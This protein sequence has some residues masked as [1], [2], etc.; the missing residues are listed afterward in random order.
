MFFRELVHLLQAVT[1]Q[2]RRSS[3]VPVLSVSAQARPSFPAL[4]PCA[5]SPPPSIS[6]ARGLSAFLPLFK[7]PVLCF[8]DLSLLFLFFISLT[9]DLIPSLL[10]VSGLICSSLSSVLRWNLNSR[11][12]FPKIRIGC[13]RFPSKPSFGC[14]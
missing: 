6:L 1:V 11:P 13:Y 5:L 14:I 10:P 4:L 3:V 9:S 2:A 8:T 7:E 12:F